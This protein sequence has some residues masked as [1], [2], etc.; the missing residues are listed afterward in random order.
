MVVVARTDASDLDDICRRVQAFAELKPD[1]VLV[2]GLRDLE[3]IR[4]VARL[5]NLP[6][7]FNQIAGGKSPPAS[8]PELHERGVRLVIYSTPCLFASLTA[9]NSALK[10]IAE[11]DGRLPPDSPSVG[12]VAGLLNQNLKE[13]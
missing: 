4:Q 9:M 3:M 5:T 11:H 7:A 2:D 6:V 10:H 8:L 1:V 12:D 13:R